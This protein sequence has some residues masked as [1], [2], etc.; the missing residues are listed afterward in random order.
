VA[1][2]ANLKIQ[3]WGNSLAV[4][5]PASVA[6][7][8]GLKIGQPVHV[9][10]QDDGLLVAATGEPEL[11]FAQKLALFDPDLHG[12][13]AMITVRIGVEHI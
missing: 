6:R 9:S 4:R 5:I 10:V 11:T 12:G 13:E 8:A 2:Q 3:K 1:K 7:T